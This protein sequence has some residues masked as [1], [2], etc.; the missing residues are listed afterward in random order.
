MWNVKVK[1]AKLLTA[2]IFTFSVLHFALIPALSKA[3]IIHNLSLPK[4]NT[5]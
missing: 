1:K 2:I 5:S 4:V 3:F